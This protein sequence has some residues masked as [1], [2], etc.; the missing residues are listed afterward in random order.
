M[1]Q[2]WNFRSNI[3]SWSTYNITNGSSGY[4]ALE[5]KDSKQH[6]CVSKLDRNPMCKNRMSS[7]KSVI[8][9]WSPEMTLH[10]RTYHQL[11]AMVPPSHLS[12]CFLSVHIHDTDYDIWGFIRFAAVTKIRLIILQKFTAMIHEQNG[13]VQSC[14][15]LYVWVT[16]PES[17]NNFC[18]VFHAIR[19]Q[20]QEKLRW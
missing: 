13:Y 17:S 7:K 20:S 16:P 1:I 2:R 5:T 4:D 3:T 14:M 9:I 15:N 18:I 6:A 8:S 11:C 10:R 12:S 19:N